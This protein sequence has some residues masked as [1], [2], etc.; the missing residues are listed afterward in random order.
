MSMG[1]F[2]AVSTHHMWHWGLRA[3][4]AG[5]LY[6]K[7]YHGGLVMEIQFTNKTTAVYDS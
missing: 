4:L 1:N 2:N 6:A 3:L 7:R 5:K